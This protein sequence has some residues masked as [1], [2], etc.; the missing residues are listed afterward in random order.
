[1]R[2]IIAGGGGFIGSTLLMR[3]ADKHSC[4][5]FGH[6]SRYTDLRDLVGSRAEFVEGDVTD[7]ALLEKVIRGAD[8]VIFVAG[9]GGEA[10]CLEDPARA[11]LTHAHGAHLVLREVIRNHIAS[12]IFAS[13]IAVYGTYSARQMPLD[14]SIEPQPDDFYAAL[15]ATAEREIIDS[16]RYQILRLANVYGYGSGLS[17]HSSGVA[18]KFVE[19][20]VEGN[21]L[22]VYGEGTQLIDYV[23]VEDVCRAFEMALER[24]GENFIYNVGGGNPVSVGEIA[25]LTAGSAKD[26]LGRDVQIERVPAPPG[27]LWP[28]RWLSIEKIE[29]EWGWRPAVTMEAGVGEMLSKWRGEKLGAT[30]ER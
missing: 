19:L 22:R 28:D 18:G 7:K 30:K 24:A 17:L 2:I 3:L 10:V 27:K 25:E 9:T 16:D 15:K 8:A 14:E 12:F 20:A 4:V 6:A 1:M 21:S 5:C 26:L 29:R 13:T 11:V 23:H